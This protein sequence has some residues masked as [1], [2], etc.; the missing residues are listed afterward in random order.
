MTTNEAGYRDGTQDSPTILDVAAYILAMHDGMLSTMALQKLCFIAQGY[1]L[2]WRDRPLFDDRFEAWASGPVSRTLYNEHVGEYSVDTIPAGN[3]FNLSTDHRGLV[4]AV[5][6]KLGRVSGP[7]LGD[8][9]Q[10][11]SAW[12]VARGALGTEEKCRTLL[13]VDLIREHYVAVQR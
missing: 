2:A 9:T 5:I 8:L 3:P 1:H 10:E 6:E 4:D 13:D 11:C 12:M 7:M